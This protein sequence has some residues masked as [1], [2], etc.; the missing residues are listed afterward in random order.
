MGTGYFISVFLH[1]ILAAFWIGGMLFL[2]LVL[3]PGI[4]NHPDRTALLYKTGLTFQ[5]YGW[6]TMTGLFC[7]GL[8][9]AWLRGIPFTWDFFMHSEYGAIVRYKLTI[10]VVILLLSA[11]HDYMFGMKALDEFSSVQR[12][13]L[14]IMARWSGRLN[15]LLAFCMAFLG[16]V[17]SRGGSIGAL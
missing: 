1:V 9:N 12:K 6:I 2:P 7:T 14:L 16:V 4:K 11:I 10:F 17:L 8:L 5:F 3:L 13:R 15:L